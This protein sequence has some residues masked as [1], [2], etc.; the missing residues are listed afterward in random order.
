MCASIDGAAK[1]R[2]NVSSGMGAVSMVAALW[3][4]TVRYF[5]RAITKRRWPP[6]CQASL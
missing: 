3:V 5:T 4:L 6:R 1:E 2:G